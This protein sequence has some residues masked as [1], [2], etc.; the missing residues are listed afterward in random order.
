MCLQRRTICDH[1]DKDTDGLMTCIPLVGDSIRLCPDCLEKD[2]RF[3][4][5]CG[6][7]NSS[8]IS[9][10]CHECHGEIQD[11]FDD[12]DEEDKEYWEAES[13]FDEDD[14]MYNNEIF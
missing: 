12:M 10:Y 7:E 11:D 1:C 9:D 4:F 8:I 14:E 2:G 3:C 5:C 6:V 13:E